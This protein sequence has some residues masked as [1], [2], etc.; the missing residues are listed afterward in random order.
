M[1]PNEKHGMDDPRVFSD[2][3]TPN[4]PAGSSKSESNDIPLSDMGY[5]NP[6]E[7]DYDT[8]MNPLH[9]DKF[10][11]WYDI[12]KSDDVEGYNNMMK[13]E[14]DEKLGLLNKK[15]LYC[16][17]YSK[18]LKDLRKDNSRI[19]FETP[20]C[21]AAASASRRV[22]VCM[23]KDGAN[24][25]N[26]DI[27]G[28]NVI[29]TLV[30]ACNCVDGFEYM[31]MEML[32]A[33]MNMYDVGTLKK[34]LFHEDVLGFRPLEAAAKY[35]T[36]GLFRI[37]LETKEIYYEVIDEVGMCTYADYDV[38]DYESGSSRKRELRSPLRF[39]RMLTPNM[40][41]SFD[42]NKIHQ[43]PVVQQWITRKFIRAIPFI[44]FW[45]SVRIM[46]LVSLVVLDPG[47]MINRS[48]N[49]I[50][51][52]GH[53]SCS[54]AGDDPPINFTLFFSDLSVYLSWLII[55][56]DIVEFTYYVL[57]KDRWKLHGGFLHIFRK[58]V[59]YT[60]FYRVIQDLLAVVSLTNFYFS[61]KSDPDSIN[62]AKAVSLPLILMSFIYMLE[63]LPNFGLFA[64]TLQKM[65][66]TLIKFTFFTVFIWVIY[67]YF[68]MICLPHTDTN[69]SNLGTSIYTLFLIESGNF[70]FTIL[71][72]YV[73]LAHITY[74]YASAV[75]LLNYLIAI[76]STISDE[77][78]K[79]KELCLTL[80]RLDIAI[81]LDDRFGRW[82][83]RIIYLCSKTRKRI[84]LAVLNPQRFKRI[85]LNVELD[86][87]QSVLL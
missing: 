74:Y 75:M 55:A 42:E 63:L 30:R 64:I 69:F 45:F 31:Y 14:T 38:D 1:D 5:Y 53:R 18:K 19:E 59:S 21:V 76:M 46:F 66:T 11:A 47:L 73:M 49:C 15:F 87:E 85:K 65:A 71:T 33:V 34:L 40:L 81:L 10:K 51:E 58:Y 78:G 27:E 77:M 2:E 26:T 57:E 48:L 20:L 67:A 8:L 52:P 22:F 24:V 54:G 56:Y 3:N 72:S 82:F 86:G 44:I 16:T 37:I 79:Q 60:V 29:H 50:S 41:K 83:R 62:L 39:I 7:R 80:R 12:L 23:L 9:M 13:C 6:N 43:H 32:K 4:W 25:L 35:G 68:F 36:F 70:N 28:C 17:A 84:R 61:I